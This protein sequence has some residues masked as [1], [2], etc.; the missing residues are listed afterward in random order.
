MNLF[1][2]FGSKQYNP[3]DIKEDSATS[4]LYDTIFKSYEDSLRKSGVEKLDYNT[5]FI[6]KGIM[7]VI[8]NDSQFNI[9][10]GEFPSSLFS[11]DEVIKAVIDI[12]SKAIEEEKFG[13]FGG[14]YFCI[15]DQIENEEGFIDFKPS[16]FLIKILRMNIPYKVREIIDSNETYYDSE[17]KIVHHPFTEQHF[18]LLQKENNEYECMT[19]IHHPK[20]GKRLF[21]EPEYNDSKIFLRNTGKNLIDFFKYK[22]REV[23]GNK[24]TS[25]VDVKSLLE[26][27]FKF[28]EDNKSI[29]ERFIVDIGNT[30]YEM[31][32]EEQIASFFNS[33][34]ESL[35]LDNNISA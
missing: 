5:A 15:G 30:Y 14:A 12:P 18:R 32:T 9:R 33:V 3:F 25:Y 16:R 19:H 13:I 35:N 8:N 10:G 23:L 24:D 11:Q 28:P 22:T 2:F 29:K 34:K 7:A 1:K 26:Q 6:V 21:L 27:Y 20:T 31:A 4:H 17:L